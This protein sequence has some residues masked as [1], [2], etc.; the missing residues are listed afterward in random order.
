[1]FYTLIKLCFGVND[2]ENII[3]LDALSGDAIQ[4]Q[5]LTWQ[6]EQKFE[7]EV[8]PTLNDLNLVVGIL[9]TGKGH[10]PAKIQIFASFCTNK[11][12]KQN[13]KLIV[14]NIDSKI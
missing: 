6:F 9:E 1:M 2:S 8:L 10:R 14:K 5:K 12:N 13:S 7:A 4:F 3:K 11:L